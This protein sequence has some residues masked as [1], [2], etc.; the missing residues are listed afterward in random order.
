MTYGSSANTSRLSPD[1]RSKAAP[2]GKRENDPAI[3]H[4]RRGLIALAG[5]FH[6]LLFGPPSPPKRAAPDQLRFRG[7][8]ASHPQRQDAQINYL[9]ILTIFVKQRTYLAILPY[10]VTLPDRSPAAEKFKKNET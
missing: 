4:R 2:I 10:L 1:R 6:A 3:Q 7:L 9:D 8:K 5:A